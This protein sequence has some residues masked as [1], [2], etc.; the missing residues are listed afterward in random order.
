MTSI[1]IILYVGN[2]IVLTSNVTQLKW[3][4]S[5]LEKKFEMRNFGE[6]HYCLRVEFERNREAVSSP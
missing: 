4:K 1:V 5:E 2:L 3:L 6:L